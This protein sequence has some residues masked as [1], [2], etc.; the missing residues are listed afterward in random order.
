MHIT[1]QS[2]HK[3]LRDHP[4]LCA[5]G[6]AGPDLCRKLHLDFAAERRRLEEAFAEFAACCDWFLDC[7]PLKHVSFVSP[8]SRDLTAHVEKQ[9][10]IPASNGAVVAAVLH[11]RIPQRQLPDSPDI[12]VGIS[13]RSPTLA[14]TPERQG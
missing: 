12:K 1:E 3:L 2:F 13:L 4:H 14:G 9:S 10:G 6:L 11:L 7:T 8:L 5:A